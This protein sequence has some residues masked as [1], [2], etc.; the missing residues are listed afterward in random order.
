M[1]IYNKDIEILKHIIGYCDRIQ[2]AKE[3]FGNSY[4]SFQADY[5][6]QSACAMYILQIGEKATRL[7]ENLKTGHSNIPWRDIIGMRNIF[8]HDYERVDNKMIWET[9]SNDIISLRTRCTDIV[10]AI[11]PD[12]NPEDNDDE[13]LVDDD[14]DED[15]PLVDDD[16]DDDEI[17]LQKEAEE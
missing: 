13:L 9:L 2:R 6:Y 5:E 16:D 4:E 17:E 14:V 1:A 10:V 12:Y 15:E 8:A 3:R 7:S 11:E